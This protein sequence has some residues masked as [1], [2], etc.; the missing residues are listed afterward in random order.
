[1]RVLILGGGVI[2]VCSAWYLSRAGHQVTVVERQ[3]ET[4]METSFAN[5]GQVS[6][7]Y[8]A[9]WAAPGVPKKAVTWL[10]QKH[11][12]LRIDPI[13]FF[14]PSLQK[15]VWS[16]LL[17]CNAEAY[18]HNKS[19]MVTLAEY[20]RDCLRELRSELD[21]A[22]DQRSAGTLQ[23]FRKRKQLNASRQD[24]EVLSKSGVEYEVLDADGCVNAEPG[25]HRVVDKI[26]GGLR[27][28]G[29]E[30][31]DCFLFTKC[32]AE[33]ARQSG[34]RFVFGQH[35]DR[36][37]IDKGAV[38]GV[39][40]GGERM[41]ADKYLLATGS[42]STALARSI[43]IK[44]PIYPVKGYSLTVPVVDD[45]SAPQSTIMDETYKVAITRLGDR[46]RVGGTAEL[47]GFNLS[48][49]ER[50]TD[51]LNFVVNDLFADGGD[52]SQARYWT[53]LRPMTPDGV[54]IIGQTR[55]DN[56]YINSGHGTLGWTMAAGSG[57]LIADLM[58]ECKTSIDASL[59]QAHLA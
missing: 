53:G 16:M 38:Q 34:V 29:D 12:P 49:R 37:E 6:P 30:T 42:Y 58:C 48:L 59:Y 21:L 56:L 24:V 25:L 1:M 20:S 44:L 2:G 32:L 10:M 13:T 35:I 14:T 5:A 18:A 11:G 46:I 26:V 43:G 52:Q 4:A 51:T 41:Q 45:S 17:Q 9:P 23:L 3:A 31:G 47:T 15:W 39:E 40:V 28:P 36:I 22:Y 54:P 27:L 8:A 50:R 33:K 55:F 19:R 57:R 7:G